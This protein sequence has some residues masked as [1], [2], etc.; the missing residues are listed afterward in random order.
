VLLDDDDEQA[1]TILKLCRSAVKPEGRVILIEPLATP[2]NQP[3][4][5]LLDMTMLVMTGG[6]KRTFEEYSAL[7]AKAGF[8]IERTVAKPPPFTI[9]I[10]APV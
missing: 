2:A 10:A 1:S 3:E 5:G 8:E 9:L 7:L 4:I 6:R